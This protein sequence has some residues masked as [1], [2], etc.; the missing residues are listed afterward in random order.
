MVKYKNFISES[1]NVLSGVPKGDHLSPL[2]FLLF[3]NDVSVKIKHSKL[4]IFADD[5]K[6]IK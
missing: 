2:L 1:I 4:L 5:I 6:L 3:I